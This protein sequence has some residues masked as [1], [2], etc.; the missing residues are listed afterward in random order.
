MSSV[1]P[2]LIVILVVGLIARY[3]AHEGEEPG[4]RAG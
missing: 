2:R 1:G 3:V 4:A